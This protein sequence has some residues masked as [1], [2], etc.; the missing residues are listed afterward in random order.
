MSQCCQASLSAVSMRSLRFVD[1]QVEGVCHAGGVH[2]ACDVPLRIGLWNSGG[3]YLRIVQLESSRFRPFDG[4]PPCRRGTCSIRV[5]R[6]GGAAALA[7][8]P[9][10]PGVWFLSA[11][12]TDVAV[13]FWDK[14]SRVMRRYPLS[15]PQQH[16]LEF[17]LLA[18]LAV[19][20]NGTV[21]LGVG[22]TL[23]GIDEAT[24][25]A[26]F[27]SPPQPGPVNP[28]AAI[29]SLAVG[30]SGQLAI[31]YSQSPYVDVRSTSGEYST[32]TLP[33]GLLAN[34]VA[35]LPNGALG[36]AATA[37]SGI[38]Y[39]AVVIF[40]SDG[41]VSSVAAP[42]WG[43]STAG[44]RFLTSMQDVAFVSP[45]EAGRPARV[46]SAISQSHLPAG[47]VLRVGPDPRSLGHGYLHRRK[48]AL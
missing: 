24:K 31:A 3:M 22:R 32:F 46:V 17:G 1:H 13:F 45:P 30:P 42:S 21:W 7:V 43:I 29:E 8:D 35:Y 12:S 36:V 15:D 28:L 23:V 26:T 5:Q 6:C 41:A 48:L 39:N 27:S 11:S 34:S 18:G 16:G 14:Q 44:N 25:V 37:A 9:T 33:G 47:V 40:Q 19:A 4:T 10:R 2:G 38:G 20:R